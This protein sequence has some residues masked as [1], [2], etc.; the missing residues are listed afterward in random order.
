MKIYLPLEK[1]PHTGK[2]FF[3]SK[4]SLALSNLG[5]SI[6]SDPNQTCDIALHITKIKKKINARKHVI[7]MNGV[8]HNTEQKY[9]FL[10]SLIKESSDKSDAL[11]FQSEF[12]Q[13]M[14]EKYIYRYNDK[15]KT[16]I[17]NGSKVISNYESKI[18]SNFQYNFLAFS[19]WRPHKRLKDIIKSFLAAEI[20]NSCLWIAGDIEECGISKIKKYLKNKKIKYIGVVKNELLIDYISLSDT[21]MHLCWVDWCPNSVVESICLGKTVICNNVGGTHEIVRP[22]NGIVC[23]IDKPYNYKPVNLYNPPKID[24]NIVA[25]AMKESLEKRDIYSKHVDIKNIAEQYKLF[26][27]QILER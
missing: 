17:F 26:F 5:V 7:R 3:I 18:K 19:R 1:K 25:D 6:I 11:I 13:N 21:I 20:P 4:L 8:I 10:N 16:I 12:S 27:Q 2:Y 15:H 24:I 23:D 14:F 9:K 22:S